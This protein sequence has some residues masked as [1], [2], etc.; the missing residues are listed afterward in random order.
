MACRAAERLTLFFR[1]TFRR[2][3]PT[4]EPIGGGALI[5]N[6]PFPPKPWRKRRAVFGIGPAAI[7]QQIALAKGGVH[8]EQS[9]NV[10]TGRNGAGLSGW[11]WRG[12]SG[13]RNGCLSSCNRSARADAGSHTCTN[14][15]TNSGTCSRSRAHFGQ[16]AI[17]DHGTGR[18]HPFQSGLAA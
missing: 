2:A 17:G 15:G 8:G 5:P 6:L 18:C 7:W 12:R 1:I 3:F 13:Y 14:S 10:V 11:L 9:G 16:R 4:S